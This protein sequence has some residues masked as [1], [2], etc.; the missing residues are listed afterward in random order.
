M[1]Y[2]NED[3]E[4]FASHTPRRET[5]PAPQRPAQKPRRRLRVAPILAL[6]LIISV[7]VCICFAR[8]S[9]R[10]K[11]QNEALATQIAQIQ[12]ELKATK[13]ELDKFKTTFGAAELPEMKADQSNYDEV[14][15][16]YETQIAGLVNKL[17]ELRGGLNEIKGANETSAEPQDTSDNGEPKDERKVC[18]LTFDD[19]P[20]ENTLKVLDI[21]KRYNAKA[22]FFVIGRGNLDYTKQ[23]VEGGHAVALHSN[24][25]DYG[26]IYS[27]TQAYF[28]DLQALSD[29][30]Y[31]KC[32]VRSK[33]IRFPGGSSNTTSRDYCPGIMTEL[34]RQVE[35]QGYHYFDWNID[36]EDASGH[37]IPAAEL[38]GNI[39]KHDY[40]QYTKICILCHDTD[41]KDTTVEAL[42]EMIEHLAAQGFV[43]EALTE[44][45]PEFHH[46][47]NN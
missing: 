5:P 20:S 36:S 33:L 23:I 3:F 45:S 38:V 46:G 15:G 2:T 32:G 44:D 30:V 24:T 13:G 16:A 21:L 34:T 31:K 10:Q 8:S 7:I 39:K 14:V 40:S 35:E 26:Q 41:A 12:S 1:A 47:V 17:G 37:G 27:S 6:L 9:A 19:G 43:F 25:H 28:S 18:Y 29:K 11:E 4:R 42:P 22:T